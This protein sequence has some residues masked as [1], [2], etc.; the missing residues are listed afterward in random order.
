MP[1]YAVW[2]AARKYEEEQVETL[3]FLKTNLPD[4]FVN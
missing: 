4:K 2:V 3:H 1:N